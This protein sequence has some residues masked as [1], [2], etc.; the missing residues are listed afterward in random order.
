MQNIPEFSISVLAEVPEVLHDE[1]LRFLSR[2]P[3][4]DTDRV[5]EAAIA[6]FLLQQTVG[7]SRVAAK[8]YVEATIDAPN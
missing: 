1:L 7:E 2:N 8:A 5:F 6:L 4:W 3:K